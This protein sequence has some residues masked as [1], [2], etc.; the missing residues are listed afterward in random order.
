MSSNY[1]EYSVYLDD[2]YIDVIQVAPSAKC[3]YVCEL[4]TQ[5]V[6]RLEGIERSCIS[7]CKLPSDSR[8]VDLTTL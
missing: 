3:A 7:G 5:I 2:R 8:R 6:C 4:A 1:H